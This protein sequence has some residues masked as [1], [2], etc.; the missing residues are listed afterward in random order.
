MAQPHQSPKRRRWQRTATL[1]LRWSLRLLFPAQ[2]SPPPSS[3]GRRSSLC[4]PFILFAPRTSSHSSSIGIA[5]WTVRRWTPRARMRSGRRWRLSSTRTTTSTLIGKRAVRSSKPS[6][7]HLHLTLQMQQRC[8]ARATCIA[9]MHCTDAL[10]MQHA[11]GNRVQL[12][13]H[14][15]YSIVYV[16]IGRI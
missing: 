3:A 2:R 11:N 13:L 12:Y 10:H 7:L 6:M 9:Q 14:T 8:I 1:L 16:C 4:A 15:A 5:S